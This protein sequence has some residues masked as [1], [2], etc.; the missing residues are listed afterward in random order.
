MELPPVTAGGVGVG[1]LDG[2][3]GGAERGC[4]EGDEEP[5]QQ[6]GLAGLG[7][8]YLKQTFSKMTVNH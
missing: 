2:G 1:V 7:K 6:A 8:S 4:G 5:F 3:V